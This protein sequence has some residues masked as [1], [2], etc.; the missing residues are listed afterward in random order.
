MQVGKK[1][2][3]DCLLMGKGS[4]IY[5]GKGGIGSKKI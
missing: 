2:P 1:Y 3:R 4:F 5:K